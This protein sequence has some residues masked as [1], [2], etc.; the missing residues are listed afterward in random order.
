MANTLADVAP[1]ILAQ[2]LM[3]LRNV[4]SLPGV[5]NRSYS[6]EFADHGNVVDVPIPSAVPVQ[7]VVPGPTPPATGD[8]APTTAKVELSQWKEAPFYLTDKDIQQAMRGVIPMQASEA[9]AGLIDEVNAY[10]MSQYK[11]IFGV[12]GAAGTTPLATNTS[13]ATDAR[14]IL[15][16]QKCPKSNRWMILD[17]D[18]E[19]N[20]LNLRA[21]QDASFSGSPS[22]IMEGEISRKLGFNWISDQ[23]IPTHVA[24]SLTGTI[25]ASAALLGAKTV[26]LNT[27]A[28]EAVALKEGDIISFA[29]HSQTYAVGADV[30]IGASSNGLVSIYPGLKVAL[31]GT[32]AVTLT[33]SHVVNL[34]IHRDCFAFASRP[35]ADQNGLG[36]II[37]TMSDPITGVSMRLEISREHKRTRFSYDLLY[38]ATCVRPELGVRMMG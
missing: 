34:G 8:V 9:V 30:N 16:V 3:A 23:Q 37:E 13:E 15:N 26:Q 10:I 17:P 21:F 28:A 33:G 7:N 36:N 32:E 2:G 4:N 35:L 38:G 25:T 14:K 18:A 29:G 6:D 31:A 24:G 20:A 27:D 11:R 22:A 1:K 19:G 12:A 5:V